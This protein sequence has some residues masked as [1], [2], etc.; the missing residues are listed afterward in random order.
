MAIGSNILYVDSK[1]GKVKEIYNH[2]SA[3]LMFTGRVLH[4]YYNT[5]EKVQSLISHGDIHTIGYSLEDVPED[6]KGDEVY[7][8]ANKHCV[9]YIKNRKAPA[10]KHTAREFANVLEALDKLNQNPQQ[11]TYMWKDGKWYYRLWRRRMEEMLP[12]RIFHDD[13]EDG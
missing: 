1:T 12:I 8:N 5:D 6:K 9:F 10:A 4:E 7:N 13:E 3:H 2:M 11:F